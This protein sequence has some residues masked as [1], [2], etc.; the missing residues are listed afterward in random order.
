MGEIAFL[1]GLA[2]R[3]VEIV[4]IDHKGNALCRALWPTLDTTKVYSLDL[5]EP[6]P[7]PRSTFFIEDLWP[8]RYKSA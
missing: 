5:L 7:R 3:Q 4:D 6:A 1:F 2:H 8:R